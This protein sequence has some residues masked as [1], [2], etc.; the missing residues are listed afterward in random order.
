MA[1]NV[2]TDLNAATV[3]D[4]VRFLCVDS[5]VV[6]YATAAQVLA[7]ALASGAVAVINYDADGDAENASRTSGAECVIWN[8]FPSEPTYYVD[9]T[10]LW[11]ATSS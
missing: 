8:G 4:S 11:V 10:D 9:A 1:R 6:K 7:Y 2:A 5:G 3:A